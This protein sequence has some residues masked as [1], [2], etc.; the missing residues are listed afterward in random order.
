M[1]FLPFCESWIT[2]EAAVEL[3]EMKEPPGN[4]LEALKGQI[5]PGSIVFA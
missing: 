1:C 2:L 3:A 5:V 4:R